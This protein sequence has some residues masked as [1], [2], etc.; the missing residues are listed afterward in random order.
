MSVEQL[1]QQAGWEHVRADGVLHSLLRDGLCMVDK[2]DPSGV[3]LY[4]FPCVDA[5]GVFDS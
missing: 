4:W 3:E 5:S 2:G 1:C